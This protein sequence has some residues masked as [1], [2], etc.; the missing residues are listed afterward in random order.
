MSQSQRS[1]KFGQALL[2]S[3]LSI[4]FVT[5]S[6]TYGLTYSEACFSY[7]IATITQY[8][9]IFWGSWEANSQTNEHQRRADRPNCLPA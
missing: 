4:Y 8:S 3:K 6:V 1:S 9:T 7:N 2:D 5:V